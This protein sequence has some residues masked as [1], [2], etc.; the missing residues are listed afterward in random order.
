[1]EPLACQDAL[2][3][4]AAHGWLELGDD[5]EANQELEKISAEFHSHPDVLQLRWQICA[6]AKKWEACYDI[7]NALVT[8][9]PDSADGWIH[10]A[11]AL[12]EM[13]KTKEA[14]DTLSSVADRLGNVPTVAYNLAC[15]ACQLGNLETAVEW[16]RK[17]FQIGGAEYKLMALEDRDL[18]PLWKRIGT[19]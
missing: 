11:F 12:H 4:E 18:E 16:L 19:L 3:L 9:A 7:A 6:K 15:Y 13:K 1:M 17:A 2:H 5:H 8:V 14:W 10:C